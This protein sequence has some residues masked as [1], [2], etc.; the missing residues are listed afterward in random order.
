[1]ESKS[2]EINEKYSGLEKQSREKYKKSNSSDPA[3][4]ELSRK[5]DEMLTRIKNDKDNELTQIKQIPIRYADQI[6]AQV[7]NYYNKLD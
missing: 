3:Y 6:I 2:N 1:M 7:E 5:M 4:R